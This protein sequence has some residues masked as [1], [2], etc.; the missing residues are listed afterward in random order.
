MFLHLREPYVA[1]LVARPAGSRRSIATFIGIAIIAGLLGFALENVLFGARYSKA[2]GGASAGIPFLPV[3]AVGG[4]VLAAVVPAVQPLMLPLRVAAYAGS[5]TAVEYGAC[6]L[7]RGVG[8]RPSWEYA[9][10]LDA[11][12]CI[13]VPHILAWGGLGL[14]VEQVIR[15]L[16]W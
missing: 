4:A 11:Q 10:G 16:G 6:Q 9:N 14:V 15:I 8:G 12:G 3:Y 5:L 1:P 13:D 2:L 7:D